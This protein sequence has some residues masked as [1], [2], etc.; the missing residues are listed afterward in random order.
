MRVGIFVGLAP[1][2]AGAC[3]SVK[4]NPIQVIEFMTRLNVKLAVFSPRG[5]SPYPTSVQ[6]NPGGK[7]FSW[8]VWVPLY[9]FHGNIHDVVGIITTCIGRL[10]VI[11][12]PAD[13]QKTRM[14]S[15]TERALALARLSADEAVATRGRKERT[16]LRL[17]LRAFNFNVRFDVLIHLHTLRIV[18][19]LQTVLCTLCFTLVNI[20]FQGLSLFL[21]TV[22]ASR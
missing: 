10:C 6:L 9:C 8:K 12:L 4:K 16:T 20:S 13:P 18:L 3:E 21:P 7:Y 17:V 14:L 1:S 5:S 22:V 2:L 11:I 19:A 15:E